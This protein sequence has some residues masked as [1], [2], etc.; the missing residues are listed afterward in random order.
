MVQALFYSL[1]ADCPGEPDND[2]HVDSRKVTLSNIVDQRKFKA[3]TGMFLAITGL[4]V[5][6]R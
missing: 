6:K 5:L 1:E 2:L 3:I 4:E